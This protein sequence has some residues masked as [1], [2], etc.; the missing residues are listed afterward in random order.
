MCLIA[1]NNVINI[2]INDITVYKIIKMNNE[3]IYRGFSYNYKKKYKLNKSLKIDIDG[4]RLII[5]EGFHAYTSKNIAEDNYC[6]M[7]FSEKIVEFIIPKGS[8]FVISYDDQEIV[9]NQ[10]IS[11]NLGYKNWFSYAYEKMIIVINTIADILN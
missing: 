1:K 9:S 10:I 4:R 7:I 8:E 5:F 6:D 3:S 2:A 11:G